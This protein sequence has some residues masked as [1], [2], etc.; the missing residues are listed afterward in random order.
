M[1]GEIEKGEHIGEKLS[2]TDCI[3]YGEMKER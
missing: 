1:A 2:L 3:G